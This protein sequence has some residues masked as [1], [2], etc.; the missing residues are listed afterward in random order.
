MRNSSKSQQDE[1]ESKSDHVG[2]W[3]FKLLDMELYVCTK[4]DIYWVEEIWWDLE[5]S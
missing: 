3:L 2:P 4:I 5:I 1:E